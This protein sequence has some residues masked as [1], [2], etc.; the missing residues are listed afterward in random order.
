MVVSGRNKSSSVEYN[1]PRLVDLID[2]VKTRV[3]S[4]Y[5]NNNPSRLELIDLLEAVHE[6]FA[7]RL[8]LTPK[9]TIPE[10]RD[11][12][13]GAWVYC[14]ETL[15]R[16][17]KGYMFDGNSTLY[18][19]LLKHLGINE[20]SKM[21][22]KE[23]LYYLCRFYHFLFSGPPI[24]DASLAALQLSNIKKQLAEILRNILSSEKED[25]IRILKAIPSEA[26]ID[27]SMCTLDQDYIRQADSINPERLL[28]AQLATVICKINPPQ[29]LYNQRLAY[30]LPRSERIKIGFLIY[31]MDSINDT[32]WLRNPEYNSDLFKLCDKALGNNYKYIDNETRLACLTALE[33]FFLN[34][35]NRETIE[36]ELKKHLNQDFYIDPVVRPI[37]SNL[38]KMIKKLVPDESKIPVSNV[39]KAAGVLGALAASIPGYG[40]GYAL[41]YGISLTDQISRRKN[42]MSSGAG[43]AMNVLLGTTNCY[44]GYYAA[45]IIV[46]AIT[47]RTFAKMFEVL[48]ATCGGLGAGAVAFVI[49]DLSFHIA[50]KVHKLCFHVNKDMCT[51]MKESDLLFI[52]TLLELPSEVFSETLKDKLRKIAE[53]PLLDSGLGLLAKPPQP[54]IKPLEPEPQKP[55][56]E[57]ASISMKI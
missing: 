18:N 51:K 54:V 36:V 3:R 41:G 57:K 33:S 40:A 52:M 34:D 1:P 38:N 17:K 26:S 22:Q 47:E 9:L 6:F 35:K 27:E 20:K 11:I 15:L 46:T 25:Q 12:C 50:G 53:V 28:L 4:E 5:K 21:T 30:L 23:K 32:Y 43:Y 37:L 7:K 39:T 8:Q 44:Y 45:D 55:V 49:Y 29:K 14:L 48:C 42:G 19:V 24:N 2:K 16:M 56:E 13:L 31:I 10:D